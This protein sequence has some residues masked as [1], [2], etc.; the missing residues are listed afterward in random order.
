M[1]IFLYTK[2]VGSDV[3]YGVVEKKRLGSGEKGWE[4]NAMDKK[5]LIISFKSLIISFWRK[6]CN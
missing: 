1:E 4:G 3:G 6:R 5:V 2:V